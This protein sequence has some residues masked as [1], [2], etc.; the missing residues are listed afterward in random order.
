MWRR[1]V[2][3]LL[4]FALL[5]PCSALASGLEDDPV[6]SQGQSPEVM[7]SDD[8]YVLVGIDP[9]DQEAVNSFQVFLAYL[10]ADNLEAFSAAY[11]ERGYASDGL[12]AAWFV[13]CE[14]HEI[15]LETYGI[16]S[17]SAGATIY[18]GD[19]VAYVVG[20][21]GHSYIC[22][23]YPDNKQIYGEFD[24]TQMR[25][26]ISTLKAT[27]G[28]LDDL[29]LPLQHIEEYTLA[30]KNLIGFD[31]NQTVLSLLNSIFKQFDN[32]YYVQLWSYVSSTGLLS[33]SDRT[34]TSFYDTFRSLF[35]N[36]SYHFAEVERQIDLNR[37]VVDSIKSYLLSSAWSIDSYRTDN[38]LGQSSNL[39]TSGTGLIPLIARG[40]QSESVTLTYGFRDIIGALNGN[41]DQ[42]YT[43]YDYD[44]KGELK[45]TVSQHSDLLSILISGFQDLGLDLAKLQF[46]LADDA[47]IEIK[48]QEIPNQDAFKDNFLS[49]GQAAATPDTIG[50]AGLISS[51]TTDMFKS[52]VSVS[53]FY[54]AMGD[55]SL[56]EFFTQET[57]D[58]LDATNAPATVSDDYT[59][60]ES[61]FEGYVIGEDGIVRPEDSSLFDLSSFLEGG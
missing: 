60:L 39:V 33:H 31:A 16:T 55:E 2:C 21:D 28:S 5:L 47:S 57:L 34:Y 48:T 27:V 20:K 58:N 17:N 19:N 41:L 26:D 8:F 38:N 1:C 42:S 59:D 49:G 6:Y 50:D 11:L 56:F 4:C 7:T 10:Q 30:I 44:E 9:A 61:M 24:L 18:Y 22:R 45:E 29:L 12:E 52:D 40:F 53:Q 14:L 46:V 51:S 23:F 43:S 13:F 25:N 3:A 54:Q 35:S 32:N 36:F 15:S 37:I